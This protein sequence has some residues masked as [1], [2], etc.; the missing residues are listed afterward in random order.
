MAVFD[1]ITPA[2]LA[3]RIAARVQDVPGVAV[4]AVDGAAAARPDAM[5]AAVAERLRTD[6]RAAAVIVLGDFVRPASLRFEFGHTDPDAFRD[7]WFDYPAVDREVIT[8]VRTRGEWLPRLWDPVRDRSYRDAPVTAAADQVLLV[9]GPMLLGRGLG[10]DLTV[11][12]RMSEGALLRG[13]PDADR[14]TVPP[15]LAHEHAA[16]AADIE[17]RYDHPDRP[18]VAL[19]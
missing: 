8:A 6:G 5:A 1:P 15:L 14:W 3:D 11:R 18:A 16:G 17:V 2:H 7:N 10:F 9:A 12:L 13:T 19:M 4:A